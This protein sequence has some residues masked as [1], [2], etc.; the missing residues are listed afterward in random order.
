MTTLALPT[1][2]L[3]DYHALNPLE[4]CVAGF[5]IRLRNPNTFREYQRDLKF[6]FAW[7]A[8]QQ[9]DPLLVGRFHCEGYLRML[10]TSTNS[11]T[12]RP[13]MEATVS[14]KFGTIRCFYQYATDEE[15]I[16]KDPTR[17]IARPEVD[18]DKQTRT[19]LNIVQWAQLLTAA[20]AHGPT[21]HCLVAL[22]GMR[23]LRIHEALQIN[24]E[25]ITSRAGYDMIHIIGKG[26]KA[27]DLAL[28]PP[29]AW[30]VRECAGSRTAG[31]LLLNSRG[32]RLTRDAAQR[33]LQKVAVEGAMDVEFSPHSLRRTC[34][35]F[36]LEHGQS[37]YDVQLFARH[38]DPK[39]T[40]VYDMKRTQVDRTSGAGVAAFMSSVAS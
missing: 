37:L 28:A 17:R 19:H 38:A 34:L 33:L 36:M 21:A 4:K 3:V 24:I 30:A 18:P 23:A 14:R 5:L 27:A 9:I 20:R 11:R 40:M 32:R 26:D 29:V 16:S 13:L 25:S 15:F 22:L 10:Q 39:T 2:N 1:P 7:C 35:T 8:D 12:G 6:F 31:A